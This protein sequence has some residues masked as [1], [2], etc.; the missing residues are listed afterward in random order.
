MDVNRSELMP[1][2]AQDLN[3]LRLVAI[4][5]VL[6]REQIQRLAGSEESSGRGT[7]KRLSRLMDGGY[8]VRHTMQ[9]TLPG[10]AGAAPAYYPTQKG[11]EL[12]AEYFDDDSFLATNT[13]HPRA[14]RLAHWIAIN[15][16]RILIENAAKV[17]EPL[18]VL[19]WVTE[20][21]TV[22]KD[23]AKKDQFVLHTQ[24]SES[25]PLSCSPDAAFLLEYKGRSAVYYVE[26]CRGTSSP[27]QIAARK[28][29]GY[30]KLANLGLHCKH[31]PESTRDTFRVLL[32]TTNEYRTKKIAS[33]LSGKPGADLWLIMN[34]Q[35]LTT[36]NFFTGAVA[37]DCR[38]V[39]GPLI[40]VEA[41]STVQL[42]QE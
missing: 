33:E 24:L 11:A 29:K 6:T 34:Q 16:S 2:N 20:W 14:D 27:G 42:A 31:F 7:R 30:E 18:K 39:L 4:Y 36:D 38:G 26:V 21:E 37:L 41:T 1:L 9:I 12:L 19:K 5:Y 40:N 28:T 13:R 15:D 17:C 32:I 3:V 10:K 8:I 22:N 25:P 23:A 35:M